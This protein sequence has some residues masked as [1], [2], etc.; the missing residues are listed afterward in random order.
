[1]YHV[2]KNVAIPEPRGTRG[3]DRKGFLQKL[4]VG[5]SFLIQDKGITIGRATGRFGKACKELGMKLVYRTV[6]GEGVR[7]WR[8]S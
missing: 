3:W 2:E 6:D 7:A 8:V 5:D 1:M 4:H